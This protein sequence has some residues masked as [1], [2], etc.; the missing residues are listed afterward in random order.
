[1]VYITL[2]QSPMYRQMSLEEFLMNDEPAD[3][4]I[5]K[6]ISNTRTFCLKEVPQK[7]IS[8]LSPHHMLSE[9]VNFNKR[10]E[11]VLSGDRLSYYTSF[12]IAKH[13]KGMDTL[14]KNTFDTQKRYVNCDSSSVCRGISEAVRPLLSE[15]EMTEHQKIF[16]VAE[17][18]YL[19][20]LQKAGFD[21]SKVDF[22]KVLKLSF[23]Q[24]NAP[25]SILKDMLVDLKRTLEESFGI[26]YHTS[27]FAYVKKRCTIDALK[28]HQANESR[29]Y[30][31]YDFTDFFGSTTLEYCMQ[32]CSQIFPLSEIVK[33]QGGYEE[34]KKALE[35]GFLNG[36]LPQGTPLSPTLTNIIMIPIDYALSNTLRE[37]EGQH[38]VY[39]RYADDMLISS[40]Y[41]FDFKK[42]ENL[43]LD[44]LEK[45]GAPF[46]LNCEKT[47]YGSSAGSNW[48]L[49]LMLNKDNQITVG[50]EN[51]RKLKAAL[52]NYV[53]DSKNGSPWN[54]TDVQA[55][56]GTRNYYRTVERENIDKIVAQI[57]QKFSVDVEYMIKQDL[58]TA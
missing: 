47:R 2:K 5:T 3:T 29:W 31:K 12:Y 7:Y 38:F 30:A 21:L 53:L 26:L 23:R 48:N 20:T 6:N 44:T 17:K 32:V 1:M 42:I 46:R 40:K 56:E 49:G 4:L 15:H 57:N 39:T 36:G 10:A 22:N 19:D 8:N 45:N 34:L 33:I 14:F 11:I 52:T 51:K 54:K 13:G 35:L 37:Y 16:D 27:A 55:L 41:D 25:K 50:H 24:I 28:R 18:K 58:Q 9:L 43:I